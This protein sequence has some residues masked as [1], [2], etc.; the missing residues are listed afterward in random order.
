MGDNDPVDN[1]RANDAPVA[2][3][4]RPP[5]Q[6]NEV[7]AADTIPLVV[8]VNN[9]DAESVMSFSADDVSILSGTS[10][11][12][13]GENRSSRSSDARKLEKKRP[14]MRLGFKDNTLLEDSKVVRQ[15]EVEAARKQN[16]E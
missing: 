4:S 6:A 8:H 10:K 3:D 1:V 14:G 13:H 7:P 15:G 9:E 11:E 2:D 12:E 5:E 16:G